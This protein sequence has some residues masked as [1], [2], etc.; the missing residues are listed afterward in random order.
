MIFGNFPSF[1]LSYFPFI[2]IM[3]IVCF[4]SK[5]IILKKKKNQIH[6]PSKKSAFSGF[7]VMSVASS[8]L[9]IHTQNHSIFL[10]LTCVCFYP[11]I[12]F[13]QFVSILYPTEKLMMIK[14]F[15]KSVSMLKMC[16]VQK[17]E[18]LGFWFACC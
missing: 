10:Y 15:C 11:N 13:Y 9:V 17:G 2:S 7:L 5:K 12:K 16:S 14:H 4:Y 18:V 8:F 6:F 1:S 3:S